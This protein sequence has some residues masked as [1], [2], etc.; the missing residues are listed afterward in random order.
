MGIA[1][2]H[3]SYELA[4]IASAAKQSIFPCTRRK[5]IA[6]RSLSSAALRADPLARNDVEGPQRTEYP[7]YAGY[8]DSLAT[9]KIRQ[10]GSAI[11]AF[12]DAGHAHVKGRFPVQIDN[13]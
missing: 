10:L 8:E 9:R 4:V 2:L 6:S 13:D 3:P 11:G 12:T 5:W 1:S 7:T